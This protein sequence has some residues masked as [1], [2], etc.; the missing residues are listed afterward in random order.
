MLLFHSKE[1][2]EDLPKA[3]CRALAAIFEEVEKYQAEVEWLRATHA[4][5]MGYVLKARI[6]FSRIGYSMKCRF[7]SVCTIKEVMHF[8][9]ASTWSVLITCAFVSCSD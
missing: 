7:D 1:F 9:C 3:R 2:F 5:E 6:M 4:D 8:E